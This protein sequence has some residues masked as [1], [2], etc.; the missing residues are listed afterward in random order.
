M[1][2]HFECGFSDQALNEA[3]DLPGLYP[4]KKKARQ[5]GDVQIL[6]NPLYMSIIKCFLSN[7]SLD[8]QCSELFMVAF[9]SQL[10]KEQVEL[11]WKMR[12]CPQAITKSS[13]HTGLCLGTI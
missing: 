11:E 12:T 9:L 7:S 4:F 13:S 5:A 10:S 6:L 3:L 2:L 8:T 1:A